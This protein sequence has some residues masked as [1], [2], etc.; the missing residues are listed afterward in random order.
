MLQWLDKIEIFLIKVFLVLV[1]SLVIV[2]VIIRD[3][4]WSQVLVLIDRLE[5]LVYTYGG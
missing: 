3:P 2:Q 4:R 5:G 1:A